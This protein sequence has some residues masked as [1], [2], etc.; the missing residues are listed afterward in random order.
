MRPAEVTQEEIVQAGNELQAAGRDITGSALRRALG[1][2]GN[3]VRLKQVWDEYASGLT[4]TEVEPVAALPLEVAQKVEEATRF[5]SER[6]AALASEMNNTAT[7]VAEGR[8]AEIRRVANELRAAA[9]RELEDAAQTLDDLE[10]QL[11]QAK[12]VTEGLE[13]H[14][15]ETQ[16]GA[17]A[18][19]VDLAQVRERLALIEQSAKKAAEEHAAELA[20]AK[21]GIQVATS[22][23]DEARNGLATATAKSEAASDA[24]QEHRKQAAA[25]V[26]RAA[27]RMTKVQS[28]RDGARKEAVIAREE[29]AQLR[30]R[31][32]A[33]QA[34]VGDLMNALAHRAA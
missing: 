25:E 4:A 31:V 14:L 2:K 22:E 29:T 23:R 18:Q 16:A 20:Q 15:A 10:N 19:A 11:D 30:G 26:L 12:V 1:N 6:L 33:L 13:V 3:T 21:K 27:E 8:A 32:E 28:E 17:Q 34:Q 24:L 9:E 7:K 5:M